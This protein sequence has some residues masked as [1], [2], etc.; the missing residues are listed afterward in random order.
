MI[1]VGSGV[2]L[3]A[4]GVLLVGSG[5]LL[6]GSGVLLVGSGVLLVGSGV[7][8]E[9]SPLTHGSTNQPCTGH[10]LIPSLVTVTY[11]I[12]HYPIILHTQ[13]SPSLIPHL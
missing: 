12:P 11:L 13:T 1:L 4:S 10:S 5:V 8:S 9:D 3:V 6:V 2:L 7:C